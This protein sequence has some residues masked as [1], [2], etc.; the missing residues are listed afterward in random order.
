MPF[1][2]AFDVA[3]HLGTLPARPRAA[4]VVV[5]MGRVVQFAKEVTFAHLSSQQDFV[6]PGVQ[7]PQARRC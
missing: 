3:G 1:P 6:S 2:A 7:D 5:A 4:F